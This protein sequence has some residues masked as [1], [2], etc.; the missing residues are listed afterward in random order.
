MGSRILKL[1]KRSRIHLVGWDGWFTLI[2]SILLLTLT[3]GLSLAWA[4]RYVWRVARQ[5]GYQPGPADFI[6]VLGRQLKDNHISSRFQQRLDRAATLKRPGQVIMILGGRTGTNTLSEA[7]AGKAYLVAQGIPENEIGVEDKS[8][9]TLENLRNARSRM[10]ETDTG[11]IL[12]ITNRYHL[13]RSYIMGRGLG[14]NLDTCA[15]ES[16]FKPSRS[17]RLLILREAFFLHWYHVGRI[18]S[19]WTGN[20]KSLAHIR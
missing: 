1:I 10:A 19:E 15:A 2:L 5:T 17:D 12:V 9:H 3:A 13:A 4:F 6:W 20:Q 11:R 18:W 14:L 7:A 8:R 16:M